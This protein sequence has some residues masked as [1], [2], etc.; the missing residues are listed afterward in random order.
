MKGD[1][2][3]QFKST[4][5][6][7]HTAAPQS[8]FHI[9]HQ[10]CIVK[11]VQEQFFFPVFGSKELELLHVKLSAVEQ[12]LLQVTT[13]LHSKLVKFGRFGYQL[14]CMSNTKSLYGN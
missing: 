1:E 9:F 10:I 11:F 7:D 8:L 5:L 3:Q 6:P 2:K 14:R 4:L 12:N 13:C